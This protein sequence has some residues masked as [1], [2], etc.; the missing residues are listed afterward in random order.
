MGKVFYTFVCYRGNELHVYYNVQI[1]AT[2]FPSTD[3]VSIY[4]IHLLN[5]SWYRFVHLPCTIVKYQNISILQTEQ[6]GP[7][8]LLQFCK[9]VEEGN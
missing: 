6:F 2:L 8:S 7:S 1:V 3:I 4:R 5:S 9:S